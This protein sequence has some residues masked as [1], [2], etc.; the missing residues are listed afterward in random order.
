MTHLL[1]RV[2]EFGLGALAACGCGYYALCLYSARAFLRARREGSNKN[3]VPPVSILKP[4]RGADR[5]M[6]ECFRSYCRQNYPNHEIIFGVS[7]PGDPAIALVE[8]LKREFPERRI[9]LVH[10]RARLGTNL[11]VSNLSQMLP[12]AKFEHLVVND[13]DIMVGPEYLRKIISPF[14]REGVGLVTAP[15]RGA[16]GST[17]WSKLEALGISTDFIAGVLSARVVDSSIRF[18]LGSTLAVTRRSLGAIGGFEALMDYLA[19]DYELGKRIADAGFEVVLSEEVVDTFLPDYG[20]TG[21]WKHQLR[22]M[23]SIRDSRGGGYTGLLFTF[24]LPFALTAAIATRAATWSLALLAAA[25]ILRVGVAYF[26]GT[27]ILRDRTVVRRMWMLPVRDVMAV[28]LWLVAYFS[29][30][31]VWRG[32]EFRLRKGKLARIGKGGAV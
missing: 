32:D 4:L 24:G 22:W 5:H 30:T 3:F 23:R 9:E 25:V 17:I 14:E 2:V 20:F 12:H 8:Q 16:A 10:C 15:Y 11:K 19:D 28:V 1:V 18:G 27:R 7:E 6:M 21:Y 31:V 13:S 29:H 26:V